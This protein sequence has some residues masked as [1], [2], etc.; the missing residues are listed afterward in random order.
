MVSHLK[1]LLCGSLMWLTVKPDSSVTGYLFHNIIFIWPDR[2]FWLESHDQHVLLEVKQI[3]GLLWRRVLD[4]AMSLCC[5]SIF[6][7]LFSS[8]ALCKWSHCPLNKHKLNCH[9]HS[10]FKPSACHGKGLFQEESLWHFVHWIR[11]CCWETSFVKCV[12]IYQKRKK[13]KI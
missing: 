6:S 7:L 4:R 5:T 1:M 13:I 10:L 11:W 9:C 3:P 8:L 12:N 2:A